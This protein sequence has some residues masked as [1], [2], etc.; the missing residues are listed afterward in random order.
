MWKNTGEFAHCIL[1]TVFSLDELAAVFIF[2]LMTARMSGSFAN[3]IREKSGHFIAEFIRSGRSGKMY[4][5]LDRSGKARRSPGI[6][7]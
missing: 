6:F 2:V 5:H 7:L 3:S 4:L 1:L